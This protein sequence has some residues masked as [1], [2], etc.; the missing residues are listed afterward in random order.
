MSHDSPSDA[1]PP[2][3]L[4][5]PGTD[6]GIDAHHQYEQERMTGDSAPPPN[7]GP[8]PPPRQSAH[9]PGA[10][11]KDDAHDQRDITDA[12]KDVSTL[13][14]MKDLF[15]K[16]VVDKEQFKI[17]ASSPGRKLLSTASSESSHHEPFQMFPKHERGMFEFLKKNFYDSSVSL[18]DN[19]RNFRRAIHFSA[20]SDIMDFDT[21]FSYA[22]NDST[23][24]A[25][26]MKCITDES[27][28]F[29]IENPAGRGLGSITD[30]RDGKIV[31]MHQYISDG[32]GRNTSSRI[33]R[34]ALEKFLKEHPPP[35]DRDE[36]SDNFRKGYVFTKAEFNA[37]AEV[38]S[39]FTKNFACPDKD[40]Q[41]DIGLA[42]LLCSA[43]I[44]SVIDNRALPLN[45][46]FRIWDILRTTYRV[47]RIDE[48]ERLRTLFDK[49]TYDPDT[50]LSSYFTYLQTVRQ[51]RLSITEL[52]PEV[53][54]ISDRSIGEKVWIAAKAIT[55]GGRSNSYGTL[56]HDYVKHFCDPLAD[57]IKPLSLKRSGTPLQV[58]RHNLPALIRFV[59]EIENQYSTDSRVQVPSTYSLDPVAQTSLLMTSTKSESMLRAEHTVGQSRA[60]FIDNEICLALTHPKLVQENCFVIL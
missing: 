49:T 3:P 7:A 36:G 28:A 10:P 25:Q 32:K 40:K 52:D 56:Q 59:I 48:A 30:E 2:S 21:Y 42:P 5:A 37:T 60:S 17:G 31:P 54:E 16:Y 53:F 20:G 34:Q 15:E 38:M 45:K 27:N 14:Q 55:D 24:Y 39:T 9:A 33:Y 8:T 58:D 23:M 4:Y 19:M 12:I 43:S 18:E 11:F 26:L 6:P 46:C 50:S 13:D 41:K 44:L 57:I 1:R 51:A 22:Y 29:D 47:S 35:S